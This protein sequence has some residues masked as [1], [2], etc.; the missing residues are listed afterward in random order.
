L[1]GAGVVVA[2]VSGSVL[3]GPV[4]GRRA[5][6]HAVAVL[7]TMSAATYLAIDRDR[8]IDLVAET[9]QYGPAPR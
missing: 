3:A 8:M 1:L 7:I 2:W 5:L 6:A 4:S 9:W